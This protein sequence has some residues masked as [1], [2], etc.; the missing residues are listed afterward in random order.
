MK[1]NKAIFSKEDNESVDSDITN[2]VGLS[3]VIQK[4]IQEYQNWLISSESKGEIALIHVDE[5]ASKVAAVYERIRKVVDWK[6]EHLIRRT[7]IE[8]ILKRKLI[9]ELSGLNFIS[10]LEAEKIAEPLV[11]E[12]IRGGHLSNDKIPRARILDVQKI[13]EKYIYIL[14]NNPLSKTP[15]PSRLKERV[16]F[17]NWILEIASCEI[18]ET[19]APPVKENALI[20]CMTRIMEKRIRVNPSTAITE[21]EKRIQ[22]YIAVHRALF[23]LDSPIISYRLLKIRYPEWANLPE[24]QLNE[25]A[26]NI[27]TIWEDIEKD[28]SHPLSGE[29]FKICEKYDALW[30]LLGDVLDMLSDNPLE[31]PKNISEPET[32]EN[33]VKKTYG[34]RL[35][36]LK[37]RLFRM[38]IYSTL[39]IF[40]ASGLSLFIVEVPLARLLYGK[41][42]PLAMVIDIMV[43]TLLMFLLV[44]IVRPPSLSNLER[45][46]TQ[47][48]DIVY[49]EGGKDIYEIKVRKKTKLIL[50]F[51]IGF[52]YFLASCL[53]FG[54]IIWIF[55][56][57]R[58][59]PTS[60][61]IDTF[62]VAVI[63]FA[64]LVIRQRAR[65]ITVEEKTSFWEFS[66]D[67]LSVPV[68]KIGQWVSDRWKE[69]NVVSVFFTALVD[70][71]FMAFIEFV[72]G[73]SQFLK[74]KKAEIH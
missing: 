34:K 54:I 49:Q 7:A 14:K 30:L 35:S 40:I 51:I 11:L 58:I 38:A 10:D 73:W 74:G 71:P 60:I 66:L 65:E 17:Y 45:V 37:S 19:L 21:E 52:L 36:T 15:A 22:I 39:S 55:Y 5:I 57:A 25:I 16:N 20:K 27:F 41:F 42:S 47:I 68:A 64:G 32:L 6:E 62:N 63:V 43:P 1:N 23:H 50:N 69:Y 29:F 53:S 70:M 31:I 9:S 2:M 8:R 3:P 13:L 24:L 26:Q 72:E 48:K 18:E 46:V 28:L 44:A 67:I 56:L 12:L 59:P 4:L 33:L 61:I